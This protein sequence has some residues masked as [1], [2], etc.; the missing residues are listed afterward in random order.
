MA[1]IGLPRGRSTGQGAARMGRQRGQN[2]DGSEVQ[3]PHG[4]APSM[5]RDARR[6]SKGSMGMAAEQHLSSPSPGNP[7]QTLVGASLAPMA[8]PLIDT[9]GALIDHGKVS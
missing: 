2:V 9:H 4:S 7:V 5:A 3:V 1:S 6:W 8:L